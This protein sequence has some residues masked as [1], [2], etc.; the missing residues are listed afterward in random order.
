MFHLECPVPVQVRTDAKNI[1]KHSITNLLPCVKALF[2]VLPWLAASQQY[3]ASQAATV[4][5]TRLAPHSS[6]P[7]RPR[8]NPQRHLLLHPRPLFPPR[9]PPAKA[10][11]LASPLASKAT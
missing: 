8:R 6:S 1:V 4:D 2:G 7:S 11:H 10:H 9:P 3:A 5:L